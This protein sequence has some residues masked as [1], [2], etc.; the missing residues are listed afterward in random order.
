[1]PW[2]SACDRVETVARWNKPRAK[3]AT[4]NSTR[5][6]IMS[7]VV[8]CTR[9]FNVDWNRGSDLENKSM[10]HVTRFCAANKARL[11]A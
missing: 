11:C 2:K 3:C 7:D 9:V 5:S 4:L 6:A 10:S 8:N 1:M